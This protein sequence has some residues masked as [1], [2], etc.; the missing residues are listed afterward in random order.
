MNERFEN[1]SK[2]LSYLLRHHPE[3]ANLKLDTNGWIGVD[4]LIEAINKNSNYNLTLVELKEVVQTNSK[5]RFAL[6][7]INGSLFIRANQ[8]HSLK[9]VDLGLVS[10]IPPITLY[11][12]TGE[13]YVKSILKQGLIK[14]GRQHVHLSVLKSVAKEVGERHGTPVIF[15]VD[16][17]KMIEDGIVFYLSDNGVWLTDFVDKKYLILEG[18]K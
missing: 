4:T 16:T 13:K 11:H 9:T 2:Y 12:G 17:E 7:D 18:S 1:I 10:K 3:S 14:K 8:G 5:Q 15:R 6:N